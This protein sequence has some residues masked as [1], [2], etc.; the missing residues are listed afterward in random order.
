VFFRSIF[1]NVDTGKQFNTIPHG[2][3]A[4]YFV[5]IIPDPG[6]IKAKLCKNGKAEKGG[7]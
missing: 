5:V 7:Q 4:F 1:W 2:Y 3:H 6:R